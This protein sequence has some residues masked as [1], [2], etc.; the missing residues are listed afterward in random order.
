[1]S[2]EIKY[3]VGELKAFDKI[4]EELQTRRAEVFA[5]LTVFCEQ[6]GIDGIEGIET[7]ISEEAVFPKVRF[8]DYDLSV[9]WNGERIKFQSSGGRQYHFIKAIFQAGENGI[10]HEEI[11]EMIFRDQLTDIKNIL[12]NVRKKIYEAGF[13]FEIENKNGRLTWRRLEVTPPAYMGSLLE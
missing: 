8:N 6:N 9:R 5:R 2:E 7:F 10:A 13:P 1:M 11:A 3:L 4:I 12:K